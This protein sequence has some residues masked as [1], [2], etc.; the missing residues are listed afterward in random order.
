MDMIER[1]VEELV[2]DAVQDAMRDGSPVPVSEVA[3]EII[4][5]VGY[6]AAQ[7]PR[8]IRRVAHACVAKHLIVELRNTSTV[9]AV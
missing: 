2:N 8:I 5:T 4:T 3:D 6:S 9:G 1:L 7:R